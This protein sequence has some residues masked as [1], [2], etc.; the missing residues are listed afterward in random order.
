MFK[1]GNNCRDFNIF[2]Q[3]K[4]DIPS[5]KVMND[6]SIPLDNFDYS[7]VYDSWVTKFKFH[8]LSLEWKKVL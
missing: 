4:Y 3:Y 2:E 6:I 1:S 7:T 5:F 8:T